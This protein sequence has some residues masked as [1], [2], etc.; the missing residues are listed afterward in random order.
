VLEVTA[1]CLKMSPPPR[2]KE[3]KEKPK[4]HRRG[5]LIW[6]FFKKYDRVKSKIKKRLYAQ[7]PHIVELNIDT[8]II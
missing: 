2:E 5:N 6:F 3:K 4:S 7:I 8:Q 1:L